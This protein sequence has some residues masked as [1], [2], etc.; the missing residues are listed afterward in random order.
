MLAINRSAGVT[1]E[2]NSRNPLH[3]GRKHTSLGSTL[4]LKPRAD[5]TTSPKKGN[6]WPHKKDWCPPNFFSRLFQSSWRSKL[7]PHLNKTDQVNKISCR[8][9]DDHWGNNARLLF[10]SI[11]TTRRKKALVLWSFLAGNKWVIYHVL[12]GG[13]AAVSSVCS[14]TMSD[15]WEPDE[16]ARERYYPRCE[17]QS[18]IKLIIH[19][20][21]LLT[22]PSIASETY[23]KLRGKCTAATLWA[24]HDFHAMVYIFGF[25]IIKYPIEFFHNCTKLAMLAM[26]ASS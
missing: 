21:R 6:Q 18:V 24:T 9:I 4:T 12:T 19:E 13:C 11:L 17:G 2:L 15:Y 8:K 26:K 5:V 3:T 16:W 23:D 7:T 1:L 20:V 14:I 25:F 10:P 22:E